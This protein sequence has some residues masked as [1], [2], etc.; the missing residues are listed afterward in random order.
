MKFE[1]FKVI[2]SYI[3]DQ[4]GINV[5][6]EAA[7]KWAARPSDPLPLERFAGRVV[8]DSEELDAWIAR[9]RGAPRQQKGVATSGGPRLKHRDKVVK[10]RRAVIDP[11]EANAPRHPPQ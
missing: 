3:S 4:T 2:A 11:V 6:Q 9:Q 5:T 10:E 1:R 7:R 8:A